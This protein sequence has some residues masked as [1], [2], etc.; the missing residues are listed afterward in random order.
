MEIA[1]RPTAPVSSIDPFSEPF[2]RDP[3]PAHAE[4]R[5]AGPV[6]WLEKY[7]VFAM[8][9]YKQ[10]R[11]ALMDWK[12]FSSAAG[13]GIDDFRKTR[14]WRPPSL[15]LEV[16]PPIHTK[17]HGVVGGVLSAMAAKQIRERFEAEAERLADDLVARGT[18][19]AVADLAE[20]FP[21]KV[22]GDAMGLPEAGRENLLPFSNMVFNSFGPQN[23]FYRAAQAAGEPA[24]K[25]V[26]S[27]CDRAALADGGFGAQI[28]AAA[29][30]GEVTVDEAAVLVRGLLTAGLDTTVNGLSN[31]IYAFATNPEQ[32]RIYRDEPAVRRTTFDEAIRWE[33]PVQTFFRTTTAPVEVEGISIGEGEKVLLF[34]AS[35]NRDPAKWETPDRF[36]VRRNPAG[37]VAFGLGIHGCVGQII[38]R[39]EADV[40]M[41]V[42]AKRV[43]SFE[44]AGEPERRFNNTLRGFARLPVRV[45]PV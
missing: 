18:F 35:A 28:F 1:T 24:L 8:A 19:D 20:P 30:R 33:A 2:F 17:T 26:Q 6:V 40:M 39:L 22:F 29:D 11:A 21:L 27:M 12:T 23:A 34:L 3:Y 16:D 14:P 15:M 10:V 45:K 13:V 5:A 4:L 9:R 31:T 43:A 32:W 25:W 36:D 41:T 38:A 42:M 7:G 37:H 44:L